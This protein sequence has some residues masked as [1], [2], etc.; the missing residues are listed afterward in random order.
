[1]QKTDTS[2]QERA[3]LLWLALYDIT[4]NN[5][6]L[7]LKLKDGEGVSH[8]LIISRLRTSGVIIDICKKYKNLAVYD[9]MDIEAPELR[10]TLPAYLQEAIAQGERQRLEIS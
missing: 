4:F 10:A 1:M 6:D 5:H 8:T 9:L 7:K 2:T 3:N